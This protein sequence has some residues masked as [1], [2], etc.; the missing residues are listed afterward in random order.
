[1][2]DLKL[3]FVVRPDPRTDPCR[4]AENVTDRAAPR[5]AARHPAALKLTFTACTPPRLSVIPFRRGALALVSAVPR[6]GDDDPE[7]WSRD[8]GETLGPA[9]IDGYRVAE[10]TPLAYARG[11]P[12]GTRTPG[13][14]L[15]TLFN[16]RKGQPDEPFFRAWHGGHTPLSL[17]IHPLWNYVRNVVTEPVTA[18]TPRLDAIVEEHFRSRDDLLN[19]VRFFGGPLAMVPNMARVA[20]DIR[21]FID[22]PSMETWLVDELHVRSA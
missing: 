5:L 11:W 1:M 12:D 17:H 15:L 4:F 7:D 3:Q 10:S 22:L 16:R 6:P 20:L 9:R 19:P 14:G 13:V 2:G 18:G 8:L 21:N